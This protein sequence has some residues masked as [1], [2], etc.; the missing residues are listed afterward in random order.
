MS[1]R[2]LFNNSDY[3]EMSEDQLIFYLVKDPK[4]IRHFIF[5]AIMQFSNSRHPPC[6]LG[7]ALKEGLLDGP[8]ATKELKKL[9]NL[10]AKSQLIKSITSTGEI[11]HPLRFNE[12]EAGEFLREIPTYESSGIQCRI[13]ISWEKSN[14]FTINTRTSKDS[15][16]LNKESLMSYEPVIILGDQTYTKEEIRHLMEMSDGLIFLNN[17]WVN[18]DH[19]RLHKILDLV[20]RME[21]NP[22]DPAILWEMIRAE[23]GQDSFVEI[24]GTSHLQWLQTLASKTKKLDSTEIVLSEDFK[25][26]LRPYQRSGLEWINYLSDF[27][28]GGCLADDMGLGKTIQVLAYLENRRPLGKKSLLVAPAS[29]LSNWVSE[30]RKFAPKLKCSIIRERW[31]SPSYS[32]LYITNYEM[33]P[34]LSLLMEY[35]WDTVILDEAQAIKNPDTEKSRAVKRLKSRFR[36]ALT[37]TP[38]ENRPTDLWSIFEFLNPGLLGTLL[39]FK[40][41][42]G[43]S[44]Q[45][46][47]DA[48]RL[49]RIIAPFIMRRLKTDKNIIKDLPDKIIK[50]EYVQLSELQAKLYKEQIVKMK[51][52]SELK[53]G[54]GVLSYITRFQQICNHPDLL[55][56]RPSFEESDSGK[57]MITREICEEAIERGEKLLIFTR[58]VETGKMLQKYL[59][60]IFNAK[61]LFFSGEL[62][63][64][65]RGQILSDFDNKTV[66][67]CPILIL[68]IKAG[69]SGL[70][71]QIANHVIMFD[72]W[73]NPATEKQA[74]D[75]TYR[76]GQMKDVMVHILICMNTLEEGID[77]MLKAKNEMAD[78]I[79]GNET[80][81]KDFD[82]DKLLQ[83]VGDGSIL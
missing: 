55:L 82:K 64:T 26:V 53:K 68:T 46:V 59:S 71:L 35:N 40:E 17:K 6:F 77:N 65:E 56:G 72:R 80:I 1:G 63:A 75:R 20:E 13:P 8:A 45:Y 10:T 78:S 44:C 31:R 42:Y 24:N 49:Q 41:R 67:E 19:K 58:F 38:I 83:L 14:K 33:L 5:Y 29:L 27:D 69:G 74:I 32:D 16:F 73:W 81:F 39:E 7:Y 30:A 36:L 43:N 12:H 2:G 22:L 4:D 70:N 21:K 54:V 50:T 79:L 62:N 51:Q 18:V 23:A 28:L 52:D 15:S 25:A 9:F 48:E 61:I 66:E 11:L 76:I 34:K 3:E 57:F 60:G 37:G 47:D